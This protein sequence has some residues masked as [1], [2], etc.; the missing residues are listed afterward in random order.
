MTGNEVTRELTHLERVIEQCEA[1]PSSVR[2]VW[3][4]NNAGDMEEVE[5]TAC[6]Y[7][8][9]PFKRDAVSE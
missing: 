8:C 3:T 1:D 2:V 5:L 4:V 9:R 7:C 6:P